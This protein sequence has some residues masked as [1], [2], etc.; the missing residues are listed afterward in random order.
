MRLLLATLGTD[1]DVFPHIGLGRILRER[2]HRVTI[3]APGTYRDH[4]IS[5]DLE[6]CPLTTVEETHQMLADPDLW[7]PRRSGPMMAR[8]GGGLIPRQY[9]ALS[10]IVCEQDAHLIANPAVLAARVL[11]D[12]IGCKMA[13]LVLQPGIIPS[14]DAPPEIAAGISIPTWLPRPLRQLF[15]LGVDAAG[16]L[17]VAGYLNRFRSSL[18]LSPVRRFFRWWLSPDQV[19]GLFPSWYAA[20]Q[21][22]WPPQI[23]LAGFGRYDGADSDLPSDLRDF[24]LAGPAPVVFTMGTGMVHAIPFFGAAMNACRD[25]GLRGI[26]VSKYANLAL[27]STM[28][29][30]RFA[31]F[32]QLLPLC[33]AVVHHGGIGTTAAALEAACPQLVVPLAWDQPDNASRIE[34]LGAGIRI[35]SRQRG[36]GNLASAL[37]RLLAPE[38]RRRCDEISVQANQTNGLV[39]AADWVEERFLKTTNP[40]SP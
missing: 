24:C 33:S 29:L 8:W 20:P 19:I 22:D 26:F 21:R 23:R 37:S 13:S 35:G 12:K 4:V 34:K 14:S 3:A 31:P 5:L 32:R 9:E 18:G 17:L 16:Y 28:K 15:W 40:S 36:R 30:C 1:G 7:H 27:P 6:F 2:G 39:I 10:K 25:V 11:Q 38:F